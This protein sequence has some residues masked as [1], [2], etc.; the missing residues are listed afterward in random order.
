MKNDRKNV[1]A[2]LKELV[3]LACR[4]GAS[5]AGTVSTNNISAE[6]D[7]ANMCRDSPCEH[8]G[9]SINC[10]PNVTGPSGFRELLKN[11]QQAM[12]FKI[13]VSTE[14]LLS[15]ERRD[16]FRLLH[17]IAANIELAA[18]EMG[19]RNPK[20]YA[21]GSCKLLFCQ[22]QTECRVLAEDGECRYPQVAR[23]SMSGYGINVSKLMEA[24]GW[25][26]DRITRETDPD[27]V[28]MGMLCG[29]VLI[30]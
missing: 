2:S 1:G 15:N 6:D 24:A 28:P 22:D 3:Q 9:L 10:P 29:L 17:E 30:G 19:Y 16:V 26:M 14:I 20:A 8:F 18:V 7:L 23:P 11:Y 27:A 12:V 4:L 13:D 5:D 21:G 25:T